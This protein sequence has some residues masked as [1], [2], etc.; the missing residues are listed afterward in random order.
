ML[1][2][3]VTH[4]VVVVCQQQILD[5]GDADEL[6]VFVV[7][8]TGVDGLLVNAGAPYAL[9][10]HLGSHVRPQRDELGGHDRAGAVLRIFEQLVDLLAHVLVGSAQNTLDDVGRHLFNK[11]YRVVQKQ[12]VHDLLELA[13][14]KAVDQKRLCVL[15]HFDKGLRRQLLGQKP[16]QNGH[17]FVLQ[18]LKHRRDVVGHHGD[19]DVPK[20]CKLFLIEQFFYGLRQRDVYLNH[21]LS[22]FCCGKT[23]SRVMAQ[24]KST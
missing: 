5:G 12:L 18:F 2:H 24:I 20:S 10:R 8:I 14:R 21:H 11:V 19:E 22:S 17:F 7:D 1:L 15:V 4:R 3:Q 16:E 23:R 9:D 6:V 13:V